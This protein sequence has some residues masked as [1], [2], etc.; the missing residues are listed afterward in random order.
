MIS[1]DDQTSPDSEPP[2]SMSY[3][4]LGE[5][6][7]TT[8]EKLEKFTGVV[9]WTYIKPHFESGVLLYVDPALDLTVAGEAFAMDQRE[10]VEGW[11]KSGD[12]VKPSGPH[13]VYW[14]DSK[15]LFTALV[16]SPFV[17]IQPATREN[18]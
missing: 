15:A 7:S 9:D 13:A 16:V 4:I 5:D 14:E 1:R 8:R 10:V 18:G 3:G 12:L 6:T 17:L 11:M 2:G